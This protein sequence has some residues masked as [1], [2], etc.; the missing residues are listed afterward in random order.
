MMNNGMTSPSAIAHV[1]V[2]ISPRRT[3]MSA[4]KE[5]LAAKLDRREGEV[6]EVEVSGQLPSNSIAFL[7]SFNF[8]VAMV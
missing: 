4:T 8:L 7:S 6:I 5:R 2:S 1:L 3:G